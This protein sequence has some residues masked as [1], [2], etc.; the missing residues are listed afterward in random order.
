MLSHSSCTWVWSATMRPH[1]WRHY[2]TTNMSYTS[3]SDLL[4]TAALYNHLVGRLT[5]G[6]WAYYAGY[7]APIT[8]ILVGMTESWHQARHTIR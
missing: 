8:P 3:L 7:V 5:P 1:R 2:H 4:G 6:Q